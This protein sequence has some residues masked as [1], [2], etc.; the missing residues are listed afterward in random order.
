MKNIV[1]IAGLVIVVVIFARHSTMPP[2]SSPSAI[3]VMPH[4]DL[5]KVNGGNLKSDELR[6][7]VLV[8]DF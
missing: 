1:L 3:G 5:V 6:G 7:K 8:V 2:T 4:F